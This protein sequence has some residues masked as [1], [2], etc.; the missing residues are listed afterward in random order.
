MRR[1][2]NQWTKTFFPTFRKHFEALNATICWSVL[3]KLLTIEKYGVSAFTEKKLMSSD[4]NFDFFTFFEKN[5]FFSNFENPL[6]KTAPRAVFF[7][8]MIQFQNGLKSFQII[9]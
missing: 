4:Q 1:F 7:E 9:F 2:L 8:K 6:K 5:P 3:C